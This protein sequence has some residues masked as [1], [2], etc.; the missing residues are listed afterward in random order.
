MNEKL[1]VGIV[2]ADASG[3]G[4]GPL[5]HFPALA[6]LPEYE[7]AALCT[8]RPET[9]KAAAQRYGIANAYHDVRDMASND[10]IDVVTVAVRAPNHYD[11]AMAASSGPTHTKRAA[12]PHEMKFTGRFARSGATAYA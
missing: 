9:A 5:A 7:I 6:A 4:W 3:Q 2:G 11:V 12:S 1:R 8:S 10:D